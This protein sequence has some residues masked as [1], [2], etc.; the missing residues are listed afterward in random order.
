MRNFST[1]TIFG[2]QN[3]LL[4]HLP[5]LIPSH[6]TERLFLKHKI[7]PQTPLFKTL[8]LLLIKTLR[9][10]KTNVWPVPPKPCTMWALYPYPP[11]P[12]SRHA[13]PRSR[14]SDTLVPLS[15]PKVPEPKTHCSKSDKLYLQGGNWQGPGLPEAGGRAEMPVTRKVLPQDPRETEILKISGQCLLFYYRYMRTRSGQPPPFSLALRVL[16]SW[17]GTMRQSKTK[18]KQKTDLQIVTAGITLIKTL[19]QVILERRPL[20]SKA[21]LLLQNL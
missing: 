15:F 19:S 16:G 14:S 3:N 2:G 10:K 21:P 17:P 11:V 8:Y 7:R 6:S 5:L 12:K 13:C 20:L 4:T 9:V 18:T 1:F